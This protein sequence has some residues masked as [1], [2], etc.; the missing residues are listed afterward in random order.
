MQNLFR[1][2]I[3]VDEATDFPPIQL[4]CMV[5]LCDPAANSFIA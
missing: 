3:V 2:Q 1:S 4:A 5:G